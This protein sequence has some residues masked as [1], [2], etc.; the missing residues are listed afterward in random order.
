MRWRRN[1]YPN[2]SAHI[3]ASPHPPYPPPSFSPSRNTFN[4]V[5]HSHSLGQS[6][7]RVATEKCAATM[8]CHLYSPPCVCV[9]WADTLPPLPPLTHAC[10]PHPSPHGSTD[11][12]YAL[13]LLLPPPPVSPPYP[14]P[15]IS[16]L[17]PVSVSAAVSH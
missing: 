1:E 2:K 14:L 12:N 5:R 6:Q 3:P 15:Y 9:K 4:I 17:S 10:P 16:S 8:Q 11:H 7:G 13:L